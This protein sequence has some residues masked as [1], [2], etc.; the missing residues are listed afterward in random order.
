M[1]RV[2]VAGMSS[3]RI[4]RSVPSFPIP[5][6][7]SQ[8]Q[9]DGI[10]IRLAS[11]GWTI[12][13]TLQCLGTDVE[14]ASYV[15]ADMVGQLA[16]FGLRQYG[17]YGPATLV[18]AEHPRTMVLYDRDGRRASTRDLRSVQDLR[19]PAEVFAS[20]LDAGPTSAAV[21]TNVGFTRSLIPVAVARG[22]PIVTDLQIIG[23]I[24]DPHSQ[25]WLR[26]ARIISCSHDRLPTSPESWV[27]SLWRR[28]GTDVVL[29]GCGA[30]GAVLG[31]RERDSLWHVDAVSPRGV[32]YTSGA[33]DTLLASFLH[34][35]LSLGDPVAAIRRAVLTAGWKIGGDAYEEP[36]L[37]AA[38]LAAIQANHGLPK[39]H[40]VD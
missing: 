7:P 35:Y 19:Y 13:R 14:F 12:V 34:H 5:F 32:R 9:P 36:G 4:A 22:V 26:A 16:A 27:R 10:H 3:V 1:T 28:Y 2:V 21:L 20:L 39:V 38:S 24:D 18:C 31:L 15:G 11:Q 37:S 17:L 33:G 30:H 25:P 29:I 23:D 40:R 6:V 8:R